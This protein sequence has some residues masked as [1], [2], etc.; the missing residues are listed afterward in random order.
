[1]F[2]GKY[3]KGSWKHKYTSW[4]INSSVLQTRVQFVLDKQIQQVGDNIL[5]CFGPVK[6]LASVLVIPLKEANWETYASL[7]KFSQPQTSLILTLCN[8]TQQH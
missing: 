4:S 6:S 8:A 5:Q 2:M 1:M 3:K 7:A